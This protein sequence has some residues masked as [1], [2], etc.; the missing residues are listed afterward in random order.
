MHV[1]T[2]MTKYPLKKAAIC[3]WQLLY[4]RLETGKTLGGLLVCRVLFEARHEGEGENGVRQLAQEELEQAR[5]DGRL[6]SLQHHPLPAVIHRL[7]FD[8]LRLDPG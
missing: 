6:G 8:H 4:Q 3:L 5:H 2:H 1:L 7:Q